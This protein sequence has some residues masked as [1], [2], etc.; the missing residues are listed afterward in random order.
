VREADKFLKF[1]MCLPL[2]DSSYAR[3]IRPRET[4]CKPFVKKCKRST[5][6]RASFV[7]HEKISPMQLRLLR[8]L[9]ALAG[10]LWI[11]YSSEKL[12][13]AH[14]ADRTPITIS[15]L[16][17]LLLFVAVPVCGYILLFKVFPL[18]GRFRNR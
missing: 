8:L 11:G 12:L 14:L 6:D 7:V 2:E 18:A 15:T 13:A 4:E 17:C 5:G 9:Y 16:F 10:L 1:S 3:T